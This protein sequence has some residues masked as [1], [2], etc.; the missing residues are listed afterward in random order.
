MHWRPFFIFIG[1]VLS[2]CSSN[3]EK[4]QELFTDEDN[5][6][7]YNYYEDP[8]DPLTNFSTPYTRPVYQEPEVYYDEI[9]MMQDFSDDESEKENTPEEVK[10]VERKGPR[11]FLY[12]GPP[13][14]ESSEWFFEDY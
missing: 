2:G 14:P 11:G 1:L 8:V 10:E 13:P 12:N 3:Q 7:D 9:Q 6:Y 4:T 5:Y